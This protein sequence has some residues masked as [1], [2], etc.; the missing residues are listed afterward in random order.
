MR[1]SP[2]GYD[3]DCIVIGSGFGGAVMAC[4]LAESGRR[5]LVLER[6]ERYPPGSFPR[7]PLATS[8]NVWDPKQRLYGLYDMWSFRKFD[9]IVSAGLGGGSL[10]YANVMLRKPEAWFAE[11]PTDL[12]RSSGRSATTISTSVT[13]KPS[14]FSG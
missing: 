9:A 10:I 1:A 5:V 7:T 12:R 6:G 2:C 4:R 8:T 11:K 13:A 3:F 14:T